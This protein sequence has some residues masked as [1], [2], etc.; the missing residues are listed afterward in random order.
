MSKRVQLQD[1]NDKV[2]PLTATATPPKA[3]GTYTTAKWAAGTNTCTWTAVHNG[4]YIIWM[5][6]ELKDGDVSAR[7]AYKQFQML[8]TSTRLFKPALYYDTSSSNSGFM[9]RTICAPVFA[10]AGDTVIP[11]IH[12]DVADV[13]Y[14]VE[15][16]GMTIAEYQ[17]VT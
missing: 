9:G 7:N 12:T 10:H 8:G 6:F 13:V 11:Y 14:N 17:Y 1:G 2:F 16:Y 15:I 5:Y 3:T 4:F